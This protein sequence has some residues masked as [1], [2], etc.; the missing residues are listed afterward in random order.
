MAITK[1]IADSIT[2]GAIANTPSFSIAKD[3]NQSTSADATNLI[4]WQVTNF[5]THSGVDLT[6]NKYVIPTGQSG[7]YFLSLQVS[8]NYSTRFILGIWKN[9]SA[10]RELDTTGTGSLTGFNFNAILDLSAGD[11][12]KGYYYSVTSTGNIR[13][14][15]SSGSQITRLDGYKLI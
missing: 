8:F 7:K 2:S 10:I 3:S 1:L 13:Q 5:D 6:N 15:N 11:E 14:E 12:I 4:T 9:G